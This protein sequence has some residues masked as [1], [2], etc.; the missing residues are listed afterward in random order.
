MGDPL[1]GEHHK[2]VTES[3]K[4]GAVMMEA[5]TVKLPA[6]AVHCEYLTPGGNDLRGAFGKEV[7]PAFV[8]LDLASGTLRAHVA[9]GAKPPVLVGVMFFLRWPIAPVTNDRANALLDEIAPRAATLVNRV[10]TRAPGGVLFPP[11]AGNAVDRIQMACAAT[12]DD[13]ARL[14][15]D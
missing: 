14:A 10:D 1:S 2:E 6:P 7:R 15:K 5:E 4:G 3:K 8:M 9:D 13:P 12:W 11:G